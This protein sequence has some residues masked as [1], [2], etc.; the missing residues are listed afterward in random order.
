MSQMH[1]RHLGEGWF[2]VLVFLLVRVVDNSS[3]FLL[4]RRKTEDIIYL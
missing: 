1:P 3:H 4:T 2:F